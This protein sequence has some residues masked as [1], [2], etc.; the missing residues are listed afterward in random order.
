MDAAE[1][2]PIRRAL[3]YCE[4]CGAETAHRLLKLRPR[5]RGAGAALSGVA[6]CQTC[7]VTRPFLSSPERTVAFDVVAS[8][9]EKSTR[10]R[11][12]APPKARFVLGETVEVAGA[13]LRVTRLELRNGANSGSAVAERLATLWGTRAVESMVRLAVIEGARSRT[14]KVPAS[15][16]SRYEVGRTFR[17]GDATLLVTALRARGQTWRRPGDAFGSDA[18][19]V[20]YARRTDRPPAGRSR[21][22]TV[23]GTPSS[24][25]SSASTWPRSRSSPGA[26]RQR[27]SPRARTASGGA[28]VHRRSP[29]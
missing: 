3:L 23:R 25:A 13:P 28:A 29:S 10:H 26:S 12:A 21:W 8:D 11:L 27:T 22:S 7:R 18:V 24:R 20:V 4:T 19:S 15:A 5:G 14:I 1:D 2:G 17:L 9:G 16:V 6:R